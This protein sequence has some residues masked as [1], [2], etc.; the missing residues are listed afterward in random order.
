MFKKIIF[1]LFSLCYLSTS[2]AVV[3]NGYH[4]DQDYVDLAHSDERFNA[5]GYIY[6]YNKKGWS[7]GTL[8]Q[9]D[10]KAIVITCMHSLED[11]IPDDYDASKSEPIPVEGLYMG[12]GS[13]V[14]FSKS[15][16]YK[17]KSIVLNSEYIKHFRLN[18][19]NKYRYDVAFLE[20]ENRVPGVN[21]V[22]LVEAG[23]GK[24]DKGAFLGYGKC[25]KKA[26]IVP[27]LEL[28]TV[29]TREDS[30]MLMSIL[31]KPDLESNPNNNFFKKWKA[32]DFKPYAMAE[33]GDSG[34]PL[35]IKSRKG[36]IY[37]AGIVSGCGFTNAAK[38]KEFL[39]SIDNFES[40][41]MSNYSLDDLYDNVSILF[42]TIIDYSDRGVWL[43]GSIDEMFKITQGKKLLHNKSL[44]D[45]YCDIESKC[46]LTEHIL[47][48]SAALDLE[49][50]VTIS[51][52]APAY[53]LM[54]NSNENIGINNV[55]IERN[56]F[57]YSLRGKFYDI[58]G[59]MNLFSLNRTG[60]SRAS[61]DVR[62]KGFSKEA[63]KEIHDFLPLTI[64]IK[65]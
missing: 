44:I 18:S 59:I 62:I 5:I 3:S 26:A 53:D 58:L 11:Y 65:N 24:V 23:S 31:R 28:S 49:Q 39:K 7:T 55:E 47:E 45:L 10:T 46:Q 60:L 51:I 32:S 8:V 19:K 13:E 64:N 38:D 33:H 4:K 27:N 43:N 6:D 57:G 37:V 17:V 48:P 9:N 35:L 22:P 52:D 36:N 25:I 56:E 15:V 30:P 34:G 42:A 16:Q 21:A 54:L 29:R 1:S 20:L 41:D 63:N 12:F 50:P 40:I 61:I 2:F 14:M